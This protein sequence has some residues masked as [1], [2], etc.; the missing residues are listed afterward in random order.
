MLVLVEMFSHLIFTPPD[1]ITSWDQSGAGI[2]ANPGWSYPT[3]TAGQSKSLPVVKYQSH[4]LQGQDKFKRRSR[5]KVY[6]VRSKDH[7]YMC[8][9][10]KT[11]QGHG[12]GL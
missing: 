3:K 4:M 10:R 7:K 8:I 1:D 6:W 9:Q 2:S 5:V 12:G 11:D